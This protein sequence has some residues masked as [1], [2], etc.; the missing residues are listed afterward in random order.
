MGRGGEDAARGQAPHVEPRS[1]L[2]RVPPA[3]HV[4]RLRGPAGARRQGGQAQERDQ[5][6]QDPGDRAREGPGVGGADAGAGEGRH[7]LSC[8]GAGAASMAAAETKSRRGGGL[9]V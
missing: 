8:R 3:V 4:P 7:L 6:P 2:P 1:H 9:E 5:G